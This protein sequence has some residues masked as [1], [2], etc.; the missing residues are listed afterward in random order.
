MNIK[1][2][3]VLGATGQLGAYTSVALKDK[4]YNVVAVGRRDSDNGFYKTKQIDYIGGFLLEDI[5]TYRKLPKDIDAV[6]NLAGAMPAHSGMNPYPYLD[7]IVKGTVNLCEWLKNTNCKRVIFNTTPSDVC[8]FFESTLPVPNDAPRSF[9]KNGGDHA[10]YAIA[11]NAAVDILEHYWYSDGISS[12]VFRHLTVYGC[13]PDPSYF[14]N[15]EKKILPWRIIINRAQNGKPVEVWGDPCRLKE[16]LYIKDFTEAIYCA[17]ESNERGIFN[18]SGIKPYTL[19]EQIDGI[20]EV[21]DISKKSIKLFC[22]E[23][24]NTPQNLLD[25][26]ETR[27]RLNWYPKYDWVSACK[28]MQKDM[29]ENPYSILWGEIIEF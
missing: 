3:I 9:P 22:P 15:G 19:E 11:K 16:L 4:G 2:I 20:I 24:P 13:H 23:K 27:N 17:L 10:I 18:L 26:T 6:V 28:D 29:K 8:A 12:C 14:I 1:K 21:F 7:T 5:N 25:S